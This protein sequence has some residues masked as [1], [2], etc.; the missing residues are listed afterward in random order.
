MTTK[1]TDVGSSSFN[2]M[3]SSVD[4]RSEYVENRAGANVRLNNFLTPYTL[5][6][7]SSILNAPCG[8]SNGVYP[9]L[10]PIQTFGEELVVNGDFDTDSDWD[11]LNA[12]I[13][14]GKATVNVVNGAFSFVNQD[15]SFTSGKKYKL[16][17]QVKGLSGSSGKEMRFQDNSSN[18]GGLNSVRGSV[19][20]NE[21]LQDIELYWVANSNS[22]QLIIAR[23]SNTGNYSFEIDNV[24]VKEVT[25]ADFDFQRGS[26]ATRVNSQG[27]IENVQTL[28]GN[29]VQNGDFSEIGS[30]LVTNGDFA[31]D[32]NWNGV[33]INGV[34]ISNGSLNYSETPNGTNI[35]QSSVVE[36]GKRYKVTFTISN[37][38]KGGI[39]LVLGAGGTTQEISANGTF[40]LYGV[41]SIN[42]ILYVQARGAS[43]TTLSIDNVSV[44]EVGQNWSFGS[45]W[46]IGDGEVTKS[47]TDLS[48]LT[49]S[50]LTSVVGKTYRVKASITNV[51]TG[52]VRIDNFTSGTTYTSDTEVDVT[53]TATTAGVFRFLGWNGF[54]GSITNISVLEV[55]DDT[56]LPRID[57]TDGCGSLLLEPQSTNL[58]PYSEDFSDSSWDKMSTTVV[59]D[60]AI[61]PSGLMNGDKVVSN[62]AN[63][64]HNIRQNILPT[65]TESISVFAK[66]AGWKYFFYRLNISGVWYN[67]IFDLEDGVVTLNESGSEYSIED[68]GNGWYRCVLNV[69]NRTHNLVQFGISKHSNSHTSQGDGTSGVFM[70]GSQ[71]EDLSYATS[72]IPTNGSSATRLADVCNNAGSSDL[73]NS[74]EGVLYF[75]LKALTNGGSYR[76]LGLSNSN[77]SNAVNLLYRF[78]S[79]E[80]WMQVRTNN[81]ETNIV[82]YDVNQ[83][84]SNKIALSYKENDFRLWVNGIE[85]GTNNNGLPPIGLQTLKFSRGGGG[86]FFYGNVK[87][88]AVFKEALTN[89]ELAKI[90]STTQQEAFYEMRDKMLQIDAD[91]YEFG[92]YTTRLKKLF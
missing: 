67:T 45:G 78:E 2:D 29:L 88:I 19:T 7:K 51:T 90:T 89:D 20:L 54:N 58:L 86:E 35:T 27:L 83:S 72:Y 9:S 34:N 57:Y 47:G 23:S 43:G 77:N 41:A 85:K 42:T 69:V 44:K 59:A 17:A 26:A 21:S 55:T 39:L 1:T 76:A 70:W 38:V 56:D 84:Q 18:S 91:Y 87:S 60:A 25:D 71:L 66:Q 15:K 10:R 46:S 82:L 75:E 92:D 49:Q 65:A 52:N 22:I 33:G 28:S 3:I 36:I 73:I 32:S 24:S 13:N 11:K 6:N 74:T 63:A 8:Y 64:E 14:N 53:F 4:R 37:Y 48:Y 50:S 16:T 68:Y 81:V 61:S 62:T 12:T 5:D 30:E 31:T 79:N 40:T 80:I